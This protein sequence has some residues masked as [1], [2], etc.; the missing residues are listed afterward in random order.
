M[1]ETTDDRGPPRIVVGAQ[2]VAGVIARSDIARSKA[3]V[4]A[5]ALIAFAIALAGRYSV[6][7]MGTETIGRVDNWTGAVEMCFH[8]TGPQGTCLEF[9][10]RD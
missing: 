3:I 6:A 7:T 5:G 2:Q 9:K 1:T 4:I 8:Q 10:G